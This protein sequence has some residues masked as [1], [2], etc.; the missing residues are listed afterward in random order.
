MLCYHA[1]I[2]VRPPFDCP[3]Y[4]SRYSSATADNTPVQRSAGSPQ[5]S[6]SMCKPAL[7]SSPTLLLLVQH[8]NCSWYIIATEM[9]TKHGPSP[10]LHALTQV[11]IILGSPKHR[12]T[13]CRVN[14][15]NTDN[16]LQLMKTCHSQAT[17]QVTSRPWKYKSSIQYSATNGK[18]LTGGH[19]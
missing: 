17:A 2:V 9:I 4:L 13:D 16:W 18:L 11:H 14:M 5:Q 15:W 6:N 19:V 10:Q 1:T 12:L 3:P 7:S 8:N